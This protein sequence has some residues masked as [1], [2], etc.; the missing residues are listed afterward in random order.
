MTLGSY[1][2]PIAQYTPTPTVYHQ[3][4]T[5]IKRLRTWST[6]HQPAVSLHHNSVL[7]P[8][9]RAAL[10]PMLVSG[11]G[12][13]KQR[14]ASTIDRGLATREIDLISNFKVRLHFRRGFTF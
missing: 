3:R 10:L 7:A 5:V 14:R 6:L 12:D 9:G 8:P 4:T 11:L 13:R 2:R 1:M